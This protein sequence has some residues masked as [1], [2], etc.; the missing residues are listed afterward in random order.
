MSEDLLHTTGHP[1]M[2]NL[3]VKKQLSLA[4]GAL[5]ALVLVVSLVALRG[6]GGAKGVR[7]KSWTG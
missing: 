5:A 4:F 6:L 2:N 7:P 1:T 3:S